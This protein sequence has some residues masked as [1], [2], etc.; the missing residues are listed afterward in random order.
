MAEEQRE[1]VTFPA[2]DPRA[3]AS[4]DEV[5][6]FQLPLSAS[7]SLMIRQRCEQKEGQACSLFG[8]NLAIDD[9]I[10]GKRV[11]KFLRKGCEFGD[12]GGCLMLSQM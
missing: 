3:T 4:P 8:L 1:P 11:A 12:S 5:V 10:K 2:G 6:E 9:A 7:Q